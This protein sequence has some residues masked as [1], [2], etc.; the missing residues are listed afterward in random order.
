M[1]QTVFKPQT[2]KVVDACTL[3][4]TVNPRNKLEF[5][6]VS[7]PYVYKKQDSSEPKQT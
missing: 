3:L 6:S 4:F 5:T 1:P 7:L 2:Q